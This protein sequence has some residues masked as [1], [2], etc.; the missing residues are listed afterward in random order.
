MY[1][2]PIQQK[3]IV[4]TIMIFPSFIHFKDMPYHPVDLYNSLI[5][6]L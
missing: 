3:P 6:L 1:L 4:V 5:E 2:N